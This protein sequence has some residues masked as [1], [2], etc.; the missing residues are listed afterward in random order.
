MAYSRKKDTWPLL[1]KLCHT[2]KCLAPLQ[3]I[4]YC[5]KEGDYFEEGSRPKW[6]AM[7]RVAKETVVKELLTFTPEDFGMM[8]PGTYN[9]SVRAM[10]DF[11]L[12]FEAPL[13]HVGTRGF[14]YHGVPGA[15]KSHK[16]RMENPGAFI[17]S[18]NK[19]WD[20]Y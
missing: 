11:R 6:H 10:S 15:G 8:K 9:Q 12:R 7:A 17:K 1:R 5:M 20:G 13:E 4:E 14:W 19:W 2:E 18:Q 3:S 16:A